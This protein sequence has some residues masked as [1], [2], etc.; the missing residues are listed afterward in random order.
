MNTEMA[1]RA[2]RYLETMVAPMTLFR[3]VQHGMMQNHTPF[4]AADAGHSAQALLMALFFG[5]GVS[6][7]LFLDPAVLGFPAHLKK[8]YRRLDR[9][10]IAETLVHRDVNYPHRAAA[11]P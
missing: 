8:Q 4:A 7:V 6:P 9:R 11:F 5:I 3:K 10:H 1:I 2:D